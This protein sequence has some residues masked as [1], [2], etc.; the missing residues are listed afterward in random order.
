MTNDE[1]VLKTQ[2]EIPFGEVDIWEDNVFFFN[3]HLMITV[4]Q[5]LIV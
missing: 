2:K 4:P 3:S 1:P 5:S